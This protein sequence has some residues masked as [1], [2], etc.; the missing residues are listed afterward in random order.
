LLDTKNGKIVRHFKPKVG[1]FGGVYG[2]AIAPTGDVAATSSV[3]HSVRLW[4]V[5]T[6]EE[7]FIRTDHRAPCVWVG[8]SRDGSLL[9]SCS[10]DGDVKIRDPKTGEV[11]ETLTHGFRVNRAAFSPAGDLLAVAGHERPVVVLWERKAK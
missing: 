11:R 4:D 1:R 7:R 3:D 5:E 2:A 9:A 8:F 6:G 10:Y